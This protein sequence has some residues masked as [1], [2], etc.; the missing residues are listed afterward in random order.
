MPGKRVSDEQLITALS[1]STSITDTAKD[2][3]ITRQ[4]IYNR[5]QKPEFRKRLQSERDSKFQVAGNQLA[6][7]MAEA[8]Q[9]ILAVMKDAETAPGTRIKAAQILLDICLRTSEQ[10]DILSR[11]ENLERILAEGNDGTDVEIENDEM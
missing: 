7:G 5:L 11:I 4:A 8:I 9:T 10:L 2:L 6:G 3:G 1:V